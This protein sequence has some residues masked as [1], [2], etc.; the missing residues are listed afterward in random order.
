MRFAGTIGAIFA[1]AF[2]P[3]AL[4]QTWDATTHL[5]PSSPTSCPKANATFAI[6]LSE[7]NCR[8]RFQRGSSIALRLDKTGKSSCT[9]TALQAPLVR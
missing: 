8:L 7:P 3:S 6:T 1:V 5:T 2:A 4:A 9:T